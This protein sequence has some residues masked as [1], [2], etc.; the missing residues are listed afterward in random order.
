M[1]QRSAIGKR[2]RPVASWVRQNVIEAAPLWL[3][4]LRSA[5]EHVTVSD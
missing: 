3:Q 1:A 4:L 2:R 5:L